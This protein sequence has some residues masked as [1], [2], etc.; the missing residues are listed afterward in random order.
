MTENTSTADTEKLREATTQTNAK[1]V[2]LR[3]DIGQLTTCV[4]ARKWTH[5]TDHIITLGMESRSTWRNQHASISKQ[6]ME[7]ENLAKLHNLM[8]LQDC[9]ADTRSETMDLYNRLSI[10]ILEI[11]A[12]SRTLRPIQPTPHPETQAGHSTP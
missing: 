11:K 5:L 2:Q 1:Y 8:D 7:V 9:I 12:A 10:L 6:L 4:M 3:Q